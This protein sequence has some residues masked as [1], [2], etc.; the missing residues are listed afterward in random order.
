ML[1]QRRVNELAQVERVAEAYRRRPAVVV[2]RPS[3]APTPSSAE[4]SDCRLAGERCEEVYGSAALPRAVD[5]HTSSGKHDTSGRHETGGE[6][7]FTA[8]SLFL[9]FVFLGAVG[10]G[11][12]LARSLEGTLALVAAAG[13]IAAAWLWPRGGDRPAPAPADPP[14]DAATD[15][16]D[17]R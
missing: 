10:T 1:E 3:L 6:P 12:L 15:R 4:V 17:A 13:L 16:V 9:A 8:A 2:A 11:G 5:H 7:D 14:R